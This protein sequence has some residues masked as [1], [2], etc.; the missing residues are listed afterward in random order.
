MTA[1]A[2]TG[3]AAEKLAVQM[4]DAW[5]AFAR[6]GDPGCASAG[7][8]TGYTEARRPTM[9][10]GANTKLEDAPRDQERRA[11][12]AIPDRIFGSL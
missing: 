2:G 12:D 1:F 8:W 3:P 5:L 11:W 4:Q 7:T 9:V 6:S 10:F